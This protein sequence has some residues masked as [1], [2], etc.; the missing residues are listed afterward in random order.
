MIKATDATEKSRLDQEIQIFLR[1]TDPDVVA[2]LSRYDEGST[3]EEAANSALR[4]GVLAIRQASGSLDAGSV[5]VAGQG[6]IAE[7]KQ[8]LTDH[9]SQ[10][11][12]GVAGALRDYFDPENGS[13]PRRLQQLTKD[14]GD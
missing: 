4:V 2:E 9:A 8:V 7:M 10:S 3:R 12:T 14:G 6:L 13:L 1:I 5:K 11:I